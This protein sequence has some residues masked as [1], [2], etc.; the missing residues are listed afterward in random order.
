MQITKL[1]V[2]HFAQDSQSESLRNEKTQGFD[3][4]VSKGKHIKQYAKSLSDWKNNNGVV[5]CF[6]NFVDFKG[7]EISEAIFFSFN[8]HKLPMIFFV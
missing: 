7:Q 5:Q 3:L 2:T 4:K 1:I 8:S 6:L